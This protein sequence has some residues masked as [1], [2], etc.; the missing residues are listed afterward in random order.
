MQTAGEELNANQE[1][2]VVQPQPSS[3]PKK[4][5][6]ITVAF[7]ATVV[8]TWIAISLPKWV[9]SGVYSQD[10]PSNE[11]P[12]TTNTPN[13]SGTETKVA[14]ASERKSSTKPVTQKSI[15]DDASA[16]ES[17]LLTIDY[18]L[19][20]PMDRGFHL[21][22][23]STSAFETSNKID[24]N[25]ATNYTKS[26]K[27]IAQAQ[28]DAFGK[29]TKE[30]ETDPT[31][32]RER[33]LTG[34]VVG[35]LYSGAYE[36]ATKTSTDL[37]QQYPNGFMG[38]ILQAVAMLNTGEYDSAVAPIS[39]A[40]E[41]QEKAEATASTTYAGSLT[42]LALIRQA[43]GKMQEAERLF[44]RAIEVHEQVANKNPADS[45]PV[46]SRLSSLY[47]KQENLEK[48]AVYAKRALEIAKSVHGEESLQAAL[49]MNNLAGIYLQ[50]GKFDLSRPLLTKAV[51]LQAK[52]LGET[53]R[54]TL[55]TLS[56][57]GGLY[58]ETG[59]LAESEN[60]FKRVMEAQRRTLGDNSPEI[61]QTMENLASIY[62]EQKRYKE[63]EPLFRH[64]VKIR[65]KEL[66]A[67]HPD[68][69][70]ALNN[71][72]C[73][74]TELGQYPDAAS[75][76]N[77]AISIHRKQT[78]LNKLAVSNVF[79]NYAILYHKQN[80]TDEALQKEWRAY[81]YRKGIKK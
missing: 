10:N 47:E 7:A 48:A 74:L 6:M 43:Q 62:R 34:R 35:L 12:V 25:T 64:I 9:A 2:P 30:L 60:I 40:I 57:L 5:A 13:P 66:G 4:I 67:D 76:F 69:A 54:D 59:N 24:D 36:D 17:A 58:Y 80:R 71:L 27:A 29:L 56:N 18:L 3:L 72:G 15:L 51:T 61:A 39:K 45:I 75:C 14:T 41:L 42:T 22:T 65:R 32:S 23:P 53:N 68:T 70:T 11:K 46:L 16:L 19:A 37:V 20:P 81:E 73:I 52:V 55:L 78:S 33:M 49:C 26:L 79:E 1:T 44:L 63:A 31:I 28:F 38:F 50:Q 8:L 77:E 21:P